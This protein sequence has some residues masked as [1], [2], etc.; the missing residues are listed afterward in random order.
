MREINILNLLVACIFCV[1]IF[2]GCAT[3]PQE[4]ID[5]KD[6]L[7]KDLSSQVEELGLEIDRLRD[8]NAQSKNAKSELETKAKYLEQEVLR[9]EAELKK[10]VKIEKQ[11]KQRP[12]PEI[13]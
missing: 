3:V 6:T 1:S 5:E 9:L 8:K 10:R 2:S 4:E 12:E 11:A 13:K 7:I